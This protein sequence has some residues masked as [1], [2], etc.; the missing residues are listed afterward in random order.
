MPFFFFL[1]FMHIFV[2]SS[3]DLRD[4]RHYLHRIGLRLTRGK[5]FYPRYTRVIMGVNAEIP[6]EIVDFTVFYVR[7]GHVEQ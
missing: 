6:H 4:Y 7:M 1:S 5:N 3:C 2:F